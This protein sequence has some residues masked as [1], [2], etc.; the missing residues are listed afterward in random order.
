[1]AAQLRELIEYVSRSLVDDPDAVTIDELGDESHPVFELRVAPD[2]MGKVI[3]RNGR[4]ARAIRTLLSTAA[5]QDGRRATLEIV[6]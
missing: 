5:A 4:M 3:G 6:D 2:D 1:M